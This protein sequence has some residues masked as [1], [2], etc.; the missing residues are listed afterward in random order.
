MCGIS[1]IISLNNKPIENIEKKIKLMTK[2]LHHRGPDGEGVF[3]SENKKF[4]YFINAH[5]SGRYKVIDQL[6]FL[7]KTNK[8]DYIIA[9]RFSNKSYSKDYSFLRR[10]ANVLFQKIT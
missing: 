9:S 1:W 2:L 5:T 3:V 4:D 6:R 8:Y 7:N 10:L